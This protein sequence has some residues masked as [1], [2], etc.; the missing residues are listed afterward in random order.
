M[1]NHTEHKPKGFSIN[2]GENNEAYQKVMA[3]RK[4]KWKLLEQSNEC[5]FDFVTSS[6]IFEWLAQHS[7]VVRIDQEL[8]SRYRRFSKFA[9]VDRLISQLILFDKVHFNIGTFYSTYTDL[10]GL[11]AYDL[12]DE[13]PIIYDKQFLETYRLIKPLVMPAI[14]ECFARLV[15]IPYDQAWINE[16]MGREYGNYDN[17]IS[18]LYDEYAKDACGLESHQLRIFGEMNPKY[19]GTILDFLEYV[20][21]GQACLLNGNLPVFSSVIRPAKQISTLQRK[22]KTLFRDDVLALYQIASK[23]AL[24]LSFCFESFDQVLKLRDD[25]RIGKIRNLLGSYLQALNKSE[26]DIAAEIVE[27]MIAAKKGLHGFSFTE[28][29][30]YSFI[31]KPLTYVPVVGT[32]VSIANDAIDIIKAFYKRKN[33]WIYFGIE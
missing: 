20:V 3:D 7:S 28:K 27:E 33:G 18:W 14:H 31:V 10:S 5:A 25:K 26:E 22:I 13:Y 17:L 15:D 4:A 19:E 11:K 12:F 23:Q 21:H 16:R 9:D 6:A 32:I 29:P 2:I 8:A 24:G 30:V 1:K